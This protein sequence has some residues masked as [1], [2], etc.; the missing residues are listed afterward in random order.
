MARRVTNRSAGIGGVEGIIANAPGATT[1]GTLAT[2]INNSVYQ[3]I[4]ATRAIGLARYQVARSHAPNQLTPGT[5]VPVY[6]RSFAPQVYDPKLQTPYTQNITLSVTR[7]INR[8]FTV[9]VRYTGTLGRKQ[10]GSF[11]INNNNV[12]HNPELF[13]ALTDARAGT[14]TANAPA[15]KANYTDKG[16]NPC[17]I[18]GDPVLLDQ[19]L[20]GLNINNTDRRDLALWEPSNASRHFSER[21]PAPAAKRHVPEQPVVG[22]F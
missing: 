7:Q 22:R 9:D 11:D 1:T 12:Y 4:L 14:C 18:N 19:L 15:Y 5:P 2:N 8:K 21:R 16:I 17:N 6:G 20:A 13:Q 3:N 10:L